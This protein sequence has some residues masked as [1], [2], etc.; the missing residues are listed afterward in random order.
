DTEAAAE[1]IPYDS[2]TIEATNHANYYPNAKKLTIKLTFHKESG[3]LLG[4]QVI[5]ESGVGK[6]TDVLATALFNEMTVEH[7]EDL[8]LSYD[9]RFNSDKNCVQ[10]GARR[11]VKNITASL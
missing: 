10:N 6:R 4:G 9:L 3:K 11:V 8:D 1:K 7:L 2:V 5:G